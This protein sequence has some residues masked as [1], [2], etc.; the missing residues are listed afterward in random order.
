MTKALITTIPFGVYAPASLNLLDVNNIDYIINPYN[1]KI[2][3]S[4]LRELIHDYDYLIAGSE[5]ITESVLENAEKLALIARVGVGYNNIDL[6]C[7][8]NICL[9]PGA[10]QL[11]SG[12]CQTI[13]NLCEK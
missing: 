5:P 10:L 8:D 4:Q 7:I 2:K 12:I 1:K 3:E 13:H 6:E 11:T 9:E